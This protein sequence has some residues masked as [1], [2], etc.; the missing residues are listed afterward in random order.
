MTSTTPKNNIGAYKRSPFSQRTENRDKDKQSSDDSKRTSKKLFDD[1]KGDFLTVGVLPR[2][3]G[4]L[5]YV[6]C[7]HDFDHDAKIIRFTTH[8]CPKRRLTIKKCPRTNK[9]IAI[10][11]KA[12]QT[13][14]VI[15]NFFIQ[16]FSKKNI[17]LVFLFNPSQLAFSR[18]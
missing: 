5:P 13:R 7:L 1:G 6:K 9:G 4:V 14:E 18:T 17:V 2:G 3:G 10:F 8:A 15:P 12:V 11:A 16:R